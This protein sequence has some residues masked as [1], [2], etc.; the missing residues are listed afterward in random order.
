MCI[1]DRLKDQ[2][3]RVS[4]EQ[5]LTYCYDSASY[6]DNNAQFGLN[7]CSSV[8]RYTSGTEP[9]ASRAF[10][11][12]DGWQ[13][14]YLNL[15][16]TNL[17]AANLVVLYRF[18]LAEL[19]KSS[20]DWGRVSVNS[21]LYRIYESS[22]SGTGLPGDTEQYLGSIGTPKWQSNTTIGYSLKRLSTSLNFSTISDTIRFNGA[23]PAT[24]EQNAYLDRKGYAL[25][26]L[27]VGYELND[28]VDLRFN[29]N[30]VS[31]KR[32]EEEAVGAIVSTVG[33]TFQL[34]VNARF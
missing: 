20:S 7:T 4:A 6:P 32:W 22:F 5:L 29:V 23:V 33:R 28:A 16:Q 31:N 21:N 18:D 15:A 14:T 2:L 24:I 13:S 30:N 1:R 9:N 26:N 34:S 19:F 10:S 27:Y 11:V 8:P 3:T 25:Y 17:R 12:N